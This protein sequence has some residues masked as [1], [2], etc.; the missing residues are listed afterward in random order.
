MVLEF[1]VDFC[2]FYFSIKLFKLFSISILLNIL[3][4][5]FSLWF[6]C[7]SVH[8]VCLFFVFSGL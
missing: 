6:T 2:Q 1:P 3:I 4:S 8:I 5:S 7:E